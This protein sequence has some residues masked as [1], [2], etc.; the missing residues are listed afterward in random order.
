[1]PP[2]RAAVRRARTQQPWAW[3]DLRLVPAAGTVWL[4]TLVAPHAPVRLLLTT[5]AVGALGGAAVLAGNRRATTVRRAGVASVLLGCLAA[6]TLTGAAAA[7]RGHARAVS[8]LTAAAEQQATVPVVLELDD[9]PRLLAGAGVPRVLVRAGVSEVGGRPLGGDPVLLFGSAEDWAG[10]LPGQTVRL[11]AAVRPAEPGDDVWAVL[12]ARTPPE[13]VGGPGPVQRA[14]GALRSGLADSAARTLPD[15]PAGLLPGLV[16]GDTTAMDPALAAEFRRAGLAHLTAVS[17]A[18]VAIV[19]AL[20]LVPLRSR[21]SDRRLQAAVAALAIVGFVV[22]ARPGA[23]VLRAAAMGAVGVLALASG[24]SR[25]AVPALAATVVVLLLV[26]PALATDGGFALSVA[27]TA[28]IVVLA[29]GWSRSLRRRGVWRPVADALAVSA[30]AGLVTA[31]LVAA[32][33]GV[34]SLVSLPANLLAA[35]A[36]APATVLGLLAAVVSPVLP[37]CRRRAHLAGRLARAL[38]GA[39]RRAG[40]GRARRRHR[41]AGRDARSGAAGPAARRRRRDAGAVAAVAAAHPGGAARSG[42]RRLAP[43][44]GDPWLAT[45]GPGGRRLRRRAG[46]RPRAAHRPR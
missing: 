38:A 4:L 40:R 42:A 34:V 20:V 13:P 3:L 18:N 39:G 36:V 35:P 26:R 6:V 10:L 44:A 31:P 30:A 7:V 22:L 5:A 24:R 17:G 41:L 23:S 8:P 21:G 15:R 46:R 33:S 37:R 2:P 27:A 9:D 29:P 43:A 28:A 32:L 12:S 16:V 45:L 25:A 14:A 11:R 19:V 1:V